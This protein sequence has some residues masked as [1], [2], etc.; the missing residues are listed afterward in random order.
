MPPRVDLLARVPRT[1]PRLFLRPEN[2][3]GLRKLAHGRLE[4]L[5][6]KL[7]R[8]CDKL[9]ASPPPT[10]E[11]PRYP[12][13]CVRRSE[14]WR[15]IWWGNRKK[16]IATLGNAATLGFAWRLSGEK[17]Y[18]DLARRLLMA[19]ARW[20]P[21]GSTGYF[22]NDEAGMP[23]FYY[24]A[25]T[26]TFIHDVLSEDER[27]LCREVAALRGRDMYL[28]LCPRHLWWPYAS[29]SNRA[30]HF[31]GEGGIAFLHE[32]PDAANWV[33][34][35]MQVFFHVYP[36]WSDD[37][38]GWHEGMAY[39]RSYVGRF[40]WWADVMAAAFGINA[41]RKP[42][43]S[44][45]GDYAMYMQP[46]RSLG[47]GFG[48]NTAH[49]RSAHHVPLMEI[50][51]SQSG[52]NHWAWYVL[53]HGER[54][55]PKGYMG[56]L[57]AGRTAPLPRPPSDLPS[58]RHFRG[59]GQAVLNTTLLSADENVQVLFKSSAFGS[60]SHGY[61]SQNAFLLNAFGKRLF[62]RS[63]RRD[64][65]GSLHHRDWMWRTKSVNSITVNGK[66]QTPH[67]PNAVGE[68]TAFFTS[69]L[70]DYVRGDAAEGYPGTVVR[71]TR[72]ILF[73][74]PR[75]VVLYDEIETPAPSTFQW[76]LHAAVPMKLDAAAHSV[77]VR[78]APASA[79]AWFL[80]PAELSLSLTDRFEPPP[81]PRVRLVQWHLTAATKKKEL[82]TAFV[83]A[84]RVDRDSSPSPPAF[85]RCP[86]GFSLRL[87]LS[88]GHAIVLLRREGSYDVADYGYRAFAE[89]T[90]VIREGIAKE[91]LT[92]YSP[93]KKVWS[94]K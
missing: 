15:R 10:E 56:F 64:L 24:F 86:G 47:G 65:Y 80:A 92:F 16:V 89:V 2:L 70:F 71:F 72:H 25:R 35:A 57:R 73:V 31:L 19:A 14:E 90:V 39:W 20:N 53:R 58:S 33:W 36:V 22:Y 34:F 93:V 75:W 55:A 44:Q 43:F 87:P 79:T 41:Y 76:L 84:I 40:T 30:W 59:T 48:D 49:I 28:H 45:V 77:T 27:R 82:T 4:N 94:G 38:G 7:C 61:E 42:Y 91:L 17:K 88:R 37:D 18:A 6:Q 32:I 13:S 52:N 11:P 12:A 67:S 81:R 68:I 78:N 66:G 29:H 8:Q 50:L 1:H 62:I 54:P 83:T 46:P 3:P 23:F 51:A 5:F 60:Q 21:R 9:L 74:K 26:Y 69:P 63:G 85:R